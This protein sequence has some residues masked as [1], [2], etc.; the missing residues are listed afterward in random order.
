MK[1]C[2]SLVHDEVATKEFMEF[3]KGLVSVSVY[4]LLVFKSNSVNFI[5]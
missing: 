5:V 4:G 1:N 2:G 3:V